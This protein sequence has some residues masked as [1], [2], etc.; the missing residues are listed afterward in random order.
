M[1][2][3]RRLPRP[4]PSR[5][6][7]SIALAPT[8]PG[9]LARTRTAAGPEQD[10]RVLVVVQLDGG[11]DGINTVVP[12]TGRGLRQA[13][14]GAPPADGRLIKVDDG[15]AC[16]RR[17]ATRAKL[18]ETGRLAIVQGVGYPN[19]N[20]SHFRE[21]GDLADGPAR[22]RGARRARL[23]RPR[24]RRAAR[25]TGGGRS[26]LFVGRRPPAGRRPRPSRRRPRPWSG[27]TTSPLDAAAASRPDAA[28]P[29]AAGRRPGRVRPPEHCSTPTP[30][31]TGCRA[32]RRAATATRRIPR[33]ALAGGSAG[34]PADQGRARARGSTTRRRAATTPTPASSRP[35]PRLL[36]EL[37]G[38][39][40]GVPRRPGG[41]AGWPSGCWCWCFSEFGRRV[42]ENGSAG[43]DHGTAGPVFLA[44]PGVRAGLL[45]PYPEPDRPGRRRPED[46]DR[47]PPRLRHRAGGLAR[48]CRSKAA[49][50]GA[51]E[52]LPLLHG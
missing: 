10:G 8:V 44:G 28:P 13:P 48:A 14:Q 45:G 7:R 5:I 6:R 25:A 17:W 47:L 2:T 4:R 43:T 29:D 1:L 11:N 27:S 18:L 37:S 38:G 21:H 40:A 39:A 22:R 3:R 52:P 15:S 19:P 9:F 32:G 12:F 24:P 31:P 51:F 41:G 20:R 50:G 26:A 16:T 30:P 33:P 42:A 36:D 49:L 23:A 34:R 46:G 35:T